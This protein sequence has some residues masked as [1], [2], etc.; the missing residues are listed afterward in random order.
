MLNILVCVK[1]VPEPE[2][3]VT[4]DKDAQWVTT[5]GP[6]A[7]RMN[8]F[9]ECAVEAA[10][11]I[12][13]AFPGT[14]IHILCVGPER[15]EAVIRRAIGMGADHGTHM[16]TPGENFV[17]PSILAGWMATL[18]QASGADLI[19]CG[20]M[21]E[22]LMQGQVGPLMAEYLS[23]P[24]ATAV[25]H[26]KIMPTGENVHVEREI[27]GGYREAVVLQLPALLTIQTGINQPRYPSLSNLLR[28]NQLKLN[29]LYV[30]AMDKAVT[31][32]N[33]Q[34]VS[35]PR[36]LRAGIFLEGS[37]SQKAEQLLTLLSDRLFLS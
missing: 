8:H 17:D 25:V 26:I 5:P 22:D 21:S 24:C 7:F 28:A 29:T 9:D 20:T 32:Q 14:M 30:D 3:V 35:L 33:V 36:K 37:P 23:L 15:S 34:Q 31:L 2:A 10:V 13:E 19:F 6:S 12:K 16:I 4:I 11:Q 18:S 1:Q 27:E